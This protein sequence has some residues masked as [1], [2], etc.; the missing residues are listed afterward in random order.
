MWCIVLQNWLERVQYG[1]VTDK[2]QY[3]YLGVRSRKNCSDISTVTAARKTE[4]TNRTN[5]PQQLPTQNLVIRWS[6]TL[7]QARDGSNHRLQR[8][9]WSQLAWLNESPDWGP[10]L[11]V[12]APF[13]VLWVLQDDHYKLRCQPEVT[14]QP[15]QYSYLSYNL[16]NLRA[17]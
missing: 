17:L 4:T 12:N 9:R 13:C 7:S 11:P 5:K 3:E 8:S 16:D 15:L 10:S 6:D 1:K 14:E 2:R